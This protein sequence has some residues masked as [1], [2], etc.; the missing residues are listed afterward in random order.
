MKKYS[1]LKTALVVA[2]MSFS[3]INTVIAADTPI[4]L[5]GDVIEYN[6]QTDM[7]IATGGVTI[8]RDGGI[9]TG[10]Q[11]TYNFK[12]QEASIT[13]GVTANKDD[14]NL[15]A[16]SLIS[17][18]NQEVVAKGS[19]VLVKADNT[20]TG[21]EIHYNQA[22]SDISMPLGGNATGPQADIRGD[23]L[24]G[25]LMTNKYT[26][27]GNVYLNSKTNDVQSTSD[28]ATYSGNGQDFNF[29]ATGNVNIKSPSRNIATNSDN[30][31]YNSTEN[32][33]LVLTGNAVATQNGNIVRGNTLTVYL[34]D[35]VNIK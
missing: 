2:I 33:K 9:L 12:T 15:K 19:V 35:N 30:A 27:T 6:A 20:L 24:S 10:G 11:A 31:T 5:K 17:N 23:V 1:K 16:E 32:G 28:T 7:A 25:N 22:T 18:A 3:M 8:I 14:M 26:A 34:G 29:V 21:E 4:E 13:G